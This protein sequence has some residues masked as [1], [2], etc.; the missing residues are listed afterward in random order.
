MSISRKWSITPNAY[1]LQIS[2]CPLE[3]WE[4]RFTEGNKSIRKHGKRTKRGRIFVFFTRGIWYRKKKDYE[5][6]CTL[7]DDFR[8]I[9]GLEPDFISYIENKHVLQE[10]QIRFIKSSVKRK[11]DGEYIYIRDR[12]ILNTIKRLKAEIELFENANSGKQKTVTEILV[13]LYRGEKL[14]YL[15]KRNLTVEE[16]FTL[17]K[18]FNKKAA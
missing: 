15:H 11:V 12:K 2:K 6:W 5:A 18:S 9:I 7:F 4:G 13:S 17:I 10:A 3:A 14:Q 16:Y 8:N 1:Y